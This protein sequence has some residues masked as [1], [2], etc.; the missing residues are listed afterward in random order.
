MSPR[1]SNGSAPVGLRLSE[2]HLLLS[3]TCEGLLDRLRSSYEFHRQLESPLAFCLRERRALAFWW[4]AFCLVT[5]AAVLLIDPAFFYPRLQTDPLNY[6]LKAKWL[7]DHGNT[8][9]RVAINTPPFA[10]AAMPGVLRAPIIAMFS[11]FDNQ[12]RAIQIVN[13]PVVAA[14]ATMS[15]YIFSW[16]QPV[17]RHW[18]VVAFAFG[19][20]LL[21]PI[22]I[23]NVLLPLSDAP[24]AV[25]T[26]GSILLAISLICS[27]GS[28]RTR[29][30]MIALLAVTFGIA[31]MLRF[32]GPV[33]VVFAGL[34]ARGR[35]RSGVLSRG[36]KLWATGGVT[37]LMALLVAINGQAIFGRYFFEPLTFLI[38]G[39]KPGMV[40]NVLGVALP[41][42]VIPN[43]QL[44]FVHPP[45]NAHY[46]TTFGGTPADAAWMFVGLSIS[47]LI[48]TG[49]WQARARFM[50]EIMYV[51]VPL[52]LLGLVLPSTTR[53]TMSYQPFIW[54]FF[55]LGV[56]RA[57]RLPWLKALSLPRSR[58][59]V[60]T[61]AIAMMAGVAGLRLWRFGGTASE[62]VQAVHLSEAPRYI[63]D[64]SDTFRGLRRFIESL[65]RSRSLLIGDGGTTGRWTLISGSEY[66]HP[67]PSLSGVVS[68]ID[69]YL[70][71]ECGTL[72]VCQSWA[73]YLDLM[74][75]R[76]A[77]FGEFAFES[78]YASASD[79]ARVEVFRVRRADPLLKAQ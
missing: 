56:E 50:P 64:V 53:Y 27:P 73:F 38:K 54:I 23:A 2:A 60:A 58:I 31:F 28:F 5:L 79:R 63:S 78:V 68:E 74:K 61:A 70:V 6:Y 12:L 29:W 51:L 65:P 52:P 75:R 30:P 67:D 21:S 66:Y 39:D 49:I 62:R 32:T 8:S 22:W 13:I 36:T 44:G 9:A 25:F 40:L 57:L 77:A 16:S 34:L 24:Y 76:L 45:I 41:S 1:R 11:D 17:R 14:L 35:W 4:G 7:V 43:F 46:S 33:L 18:M 15:A 71:V 55:Y 47:A 10:Y 37:L 3:T 59:A 48:I 26:L 20:T 72:E 69:V 42:Q 19:F